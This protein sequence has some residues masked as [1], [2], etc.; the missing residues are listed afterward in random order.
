MFFSLRSMAFGG[1]NEEKRFDS[2][3][4]ANAIWKKWLTQIGIDIL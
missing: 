3:S 1:N 4:I 2:K